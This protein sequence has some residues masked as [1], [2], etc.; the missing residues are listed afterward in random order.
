MFESAINK[1]PEELKSGKKFHT[2]ED[3]SGL[4]ALVKALP[5]LVFIL[6]EDGRYVE[7]LSDDETRL[8]KEAEQLKGQLMIDVLPSPVA[9]D[10]LAAVQDTLKTGNS[11]SVEYELDVPAGK[12]WFE[13]LTAP[14]QK[15]DADGK[16]LVL[17]VARDITDRK[18][19]EFQREEVIGQ[20]QEAL[21]QVNKLHRL[22]PI[23]SACKK[24]RDDDGYWSQVEDYISQNSEIEFTHGICPDCMNKLYPGFNIPDSD[25]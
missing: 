5:D 11:N 12:L 17:W 18:Q 21:D 25:E 23:C 6:N 8:F 3:F 24:I 1:T 22:L 20:L 7:I 2:Y 4:S 13:G 9:D 16:N 14:F 19:A 15:K 10:A